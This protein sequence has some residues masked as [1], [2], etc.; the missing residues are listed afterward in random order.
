MKQPSTDLP[1]YSVDKKT[2][3]FTTVR[4]PNELPLLSNLNSF[5]LWSVDQIG[6]CQ[7]LRNKATDA[8]GCRCFGHYCS[9]SDVCSPHCLDDRRQF[10]LCDSAG[11]DFIFENFVPKLL[12]RAAKTQFLDASRFIQSPQCYCS[13]Y[14]S[15]FGSL[16][17]HFVADRAS[18]H[19]SCVGFE[20]L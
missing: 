9:F 17:L 19:R 12:A 14:P 7:C 16:R 15:N 18:H 5:C 3:P 11:G 8:R 13:R 2:L 1:A 10:R 20:N 4:C 6:F